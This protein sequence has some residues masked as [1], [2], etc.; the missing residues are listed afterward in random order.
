M[1]PQQSK[2]PRHQSNNNLIYNLV[3]I[4]ILNRII[5]N[6]A[7]NQQYFKYIN[8]MFKIYLISVVKF[9]ISGIKTQSNHIINKPY[10]VNINNSL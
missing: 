2:N 3:L 1:T 4:T 7:N 5:E 8:F 9:E 10:D 6:L